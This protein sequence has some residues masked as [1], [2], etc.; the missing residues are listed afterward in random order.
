[1]VMYVA[2]TCRKR[3][4]PAPLCEQGQ[5]YQHQHQIMNFHSHQG[6]WWIAACPVEAPCPSQI[7]VQIY[8]KEG[9]PTARM[10][11]FDYLFPKNLW[12][13]EPVLGKR[14]DN[15]KLCLGHPDSPRYQHDSRANR[16]VARAFGHRIYLRMLAVAFGTCR[17]HVRTTQTSSSVAMSWMCRLRD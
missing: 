7:F 5:L 9:S 13:C 10:V 3:L 11:N 16:L 4:E 15:G 2:A 14:V 6:L 1:M 12:L 8:M 17:D